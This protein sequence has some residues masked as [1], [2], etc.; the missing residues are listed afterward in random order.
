MWIGGVDMADTNPIPAPAPIT[1]LC[2]QV[3]W[4][5]TGLPLYGPWAE[6]FRPLHIGPEPGAPFGRKGR[7]L[8]DAWTQVS[9]VGCDGLWL[10]DGDCAVD[11]IDFTA[12]ITAINSDKD[13]IWTGDV[14]LWPTATKSP[15]PRPGLWHTDDPYQPVEVGNRFTFCCTWLPVRVVK[16]CLSEMP[17][18]RY[19]QAGGGVDVRVAKKAEKLGVQARLVPHCRPKHL[20]Y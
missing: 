15:C 12:M 18:W 20:N 11:P 6:W 4:D 19:G 13:T 17:S 9:P 1:P 5:R 7:A 10:L 2:F 8:A 3:V 16:A 14:V